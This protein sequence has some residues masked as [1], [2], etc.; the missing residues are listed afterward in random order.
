MRAKDGLGQYGERV[1]VRHLQELG[2]EIVD[3]NWRC[4]EG[5]LDIVARE[6]DGTIVFVEVKSRSSNDYGTPAEAVTRVKRGKLRVL[7][8]RWL[9]ERRPPYSA[10]RFDVIAVLRSR[11]GPADVVHLREVM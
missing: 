11:R 2:L 4:S 7:A 3:R 9:A 1:A 5:E 8:Q 6:A 10:L